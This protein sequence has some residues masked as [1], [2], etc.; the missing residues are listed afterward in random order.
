MEIID[1]ANEIL[2]EYAAQGYELTLRQVYYQFIA[3]DWFPQSWFDEDANTKNTEKNY[4]RLGA[5]LVTGRLAGLIDWKHLVDRTRNLQSLTHWDGPADIIET[6]SRWFNLDLWARQDV[7]VQVWIEKDALLG[8]IEDVC[9]KNDVPYFSCRGYTS[10]SEMW[11]AAQR[12]V[13]HVKDGNGQGTVILH[14]GDH[15]PSGVNMTEDIGKRLKKLVE[16]HVGGARVFVVHRIALTYE[17]VQQYN[18]PPQ[19]AK[20]S[21]S[22]FKQYQAQTGLDESW[23]LDALEPDVLNTLIQD[24][25]DHFRDEKKWKKGLEEER[26][27]RD[28]LLRAS[29]HWDKLSKKLKVKKPDEEDDD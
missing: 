15:D 11:A 25:I 24:N 27:Y 16:P 1:L 19:P 28:Q 18:P 22:R 4:N 20:K 10:M 12:I 8:V 3:R 17:Q 23:E 14:L 5:T 21:D 7:R 2:E 13:S 9:T 26:H 29:L 6:A